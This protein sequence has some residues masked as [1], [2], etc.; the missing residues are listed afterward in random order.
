MRIQNQNVEEKTYKSQGVKPKLA[1]NN[2][3][4]GDSKAFLVIFFI[5]QENPK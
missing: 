4:L 2:S 1:P 3:K 5:K